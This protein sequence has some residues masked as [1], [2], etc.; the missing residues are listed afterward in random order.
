MGT[1]R[2]NPAGAP[3]R[4]TQ[5]FFCGTSRCDRHASLALGVARRASVTLAE[6]HAAAAT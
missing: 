5:I 6:N 3:T 4:G 1:T 2:A